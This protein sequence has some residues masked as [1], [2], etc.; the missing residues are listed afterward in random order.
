MIYSKR[1]FIVVGVEIDEDFRFEIE[2]E[3]LLTKDE[4]ATEVMY[5]LQD[6]IDSV[7]DLKKGESMFFRANRDNENCKG[8]ILRIR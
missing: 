8:I 2:L 6:E 5:S 7:L 3:K 1:K 4:E